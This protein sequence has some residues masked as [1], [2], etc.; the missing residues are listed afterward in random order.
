M[1][2]TFFIKCKLCIRKLSINFKLI[3]ITL[4]KNLM[5]TCLSYLGNSSRN[6][7]KLA[8]KR[9]YESYFKVIFKDSAS[10]I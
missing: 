6:F 2:S 7:C 4:H 8:K 9:I 1:K 10:V 3:F 5:N